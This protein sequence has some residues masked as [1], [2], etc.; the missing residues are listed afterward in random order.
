VG[1]FADHAFK[2]SEICPFVMSS[3]HYHRVG[4]RAAHPT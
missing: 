3:V 4:G 2:P 1:G